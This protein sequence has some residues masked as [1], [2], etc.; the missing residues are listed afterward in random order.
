MNIIAGMLNAS[1]IVALGDNFYDNGIRDGENQRK[2][3]DTVKRSYFSGYGENSPRFQETWSDVYTG[4][5]L[6]KPW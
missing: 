3:H 1:F 6:K 5:Y 2:I 4:D